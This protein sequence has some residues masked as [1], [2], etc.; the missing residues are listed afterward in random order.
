MTRRILHDVLG[1]VAV[2]AIAAALVFV[3]D[4]LRHA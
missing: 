2:V 1:S 4:V 3:A